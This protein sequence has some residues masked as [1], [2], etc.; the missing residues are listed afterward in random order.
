VKLIFQLYF[1]LLIHF[2]VITGFANAETT[3]Y[4]H[5]LMTDGFGIITEDDLAY[6]A[7]DRLISPFNPKTSNSIHWQC[8][9]IKNTKASFSSWVLENGGRF[10][11]RRERL[12]APEIQVR[13][14]NGVQLFVIQHAQQMSYCHQFVKKWNRLTLGQKIVCLNGDFGE[15]QQGLTG[16]RRLWNLEK[17]KTRLGCESY[18]YGAC[19]TRG[20]SEKKCESVVKN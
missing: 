20:C 17:Y 15:R 7:Q 18:F 11:K 19:N 9:L 12:C 8:V 6:D 14:H 10:S 3:S 4:P 13:D 2:F 1:C 5:D 16:E